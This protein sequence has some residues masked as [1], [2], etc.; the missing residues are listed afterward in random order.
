MELTILPMH[1]TVSFDSGRQ[2][3]ESKQPESANVG[4]TMAP[5]SLLPGFSGSMEKNGV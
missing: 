4:S 3:W 5:E 2:R 1:S